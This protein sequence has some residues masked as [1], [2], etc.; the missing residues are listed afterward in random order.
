MTNQMGTELNAEELMHLALHA[1]QK[2][3]PDKA[4]SLL[5][6]L[7]VIQPQNGKATYL[8][9]ALHAE[10]GM[11]DQ[12]VIEMA[13]ALELE[14]DLPTARFQLGLLHITSGKVDNAQTVWSQLDPLGEQNPLYQFKKG[15]L[16]LVRDEFGPCI[17]ALK[18]GLELNTFNEDLNIDMRR[19]LLKAEAAMSGQKPN[20]NDASE[21]SSQGGGQHILL[22]VY[23]RQDQDN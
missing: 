7:L 13:R 6:Q 8:I 3:N 16:H 17:T 11:Y 18:A 10:I 1:T 2:G 15:I 23:H 19:V 21:D 20:V 22:S 12:A 9:G 4:I 5:K 14:P